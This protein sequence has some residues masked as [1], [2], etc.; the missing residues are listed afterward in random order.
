MYG[1]LSRYPLTTVSAINCIRYWLKLTRMN[2]N[3][4]PKKAYLMLHELDRKG[5]HTWVSN[6]RLFLFKH[7][8]GY[9]WMNQGVEGMS[10]FLRVLKSRLIDCSWQR[11]QEHVENSERF[12][13]YRSF[14]LSH[15]MHQ[16]I[17][18]DMDRHLK[19]VMTKFRF[20]ISNLTVHF[21][22]Y[23]SHTVRD[24]IC[25]M[26]KESIENE[27]HFV[28]CCPF[29]LELRRKLIP[30]KFFSN[31]SAFRFTLLMSR[32]NDN[33]IKNL[34][35]YLYNAFKIREIAIS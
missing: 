1:E 29:L 33:I 27:V 25:P 31:P 20:G 21:Y 16:Y 32:K 2:D 5:K 28:L 23:R 15:N 12:S 24:L 22:R 11:W 4:I 10:L 26:C 18:Q 30:P 19:C 35:I 34:S 6:I 14:G 9:V 3:R 8:F 13:M 17:R 7:V